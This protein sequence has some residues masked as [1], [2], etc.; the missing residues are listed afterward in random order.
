MGHDHAGGPE[1][2]AAQDLTYV[3]RRLC[4]AAV[5]GTVLNLRTG[6]AVQD[7]PATGRGWGKDRQV[8]AQVLKQL[9]SGAGDL[10]GEFGAP[11]A[12]RLQGASIVGAL[13]VGSLTLRCSLDL[14]DCYMRHPVS[15]ARTKLPY[16]SLRGSYLVRQCNGRGLIVE[17]DVNLDDVTCAD[18]LRLSRARIEGYVRLDRSSLRKTDGRALNA[19]GASVGGSL[20]C[21]QSSVAGQVLLHES[22][23]GRMLSFEKSTIESPGRSAIDADRLMWVALYLCAGRTSREKY[24]CWV[25]ESEDNSR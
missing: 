17:G 20:L 6:V 21:R 5:D 7:I 11:I 10:D 1:L 25:H 14:R 8:R 18:G 12:V 15:F 16:L 13:N 9:L 2:L 24:A 3:E 23:I 4:Q 19:A 22:E